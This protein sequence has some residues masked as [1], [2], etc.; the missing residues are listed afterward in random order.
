MVNGLTAALSKILDFLKV[1]FA[2]WICLATMAQAQDLSEDELQL[3][4]NSYFD[5]F[6]VKIIYPSISLSKKISDSTAI[7]V[8]YLVD[9][10]SAA[11]MKSHFDVDGVS[12]ATSKEDGGGDNVP[13]EVRHEVGVGF[14]DVLNGGIIKGGTLSLN[15]LYSVEHDYSSFTL[16]GTFS[17]LMA[18]KNT[19]LQLGL[20]RSWD[21]VFPQIRDWKKDKDVYTI[22]L[23]LTQI[24]STRFISQAILSYNKSSG[25]LSDPYQVVQ[26]IQGDNVANYEPV[27][28]SLRIRKAAGLRA[29]YKLDSKSGFNFGLRYYWDD[30]DVKSITASVVF[31][32][33]IN[34]ALT[35]GLGI[36]HYE[37]TRA[38]FFKPE[39]AAAEPFMAVDTKLDAG[40]SNDYQFTLTFK[41]GYWRLPVLASENTQINLRVNFYQRH[42][43]TPDWHSRLTEMYAYLFSFGVRYRF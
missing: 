27:H 38:Y 15:S 43:S 24:F 39:Y 19:T 29:N 37:Q 12:S 41:G 30:W 8:R 31:Q 20:V 2:S 7:N 6:N 4:L 14:T 3:T 18:Q 9:V 34:R 35:V 1:F 21:K 32:R 13:D 23:G 26:I 36:R 40:Y 42:S 5:N 10:I 25:M 28:P 17:Y 22:S 33:H 16:A 11:S